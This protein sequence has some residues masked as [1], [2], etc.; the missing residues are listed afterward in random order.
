MVLEDG[1]LRVD[2][3]RAEDGKAVFGEGLTDEALECPGDMRKF[4]GGETRATV[5]EKEE[6]NDIRSGG[7]VVSGNA[8]AHVNDGMNVDR[9]VA[10]EI[11]HGR[12]HVCAI[13]DG[14]CG[15]FEIAFFNGGLKSE[16]WSVN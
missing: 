2:E 7:P 11:L 16:I 5:L 8:H 3:E 15:T 6:A 9:V 1:D 12:I 14:F 4:S 10:R 13:G